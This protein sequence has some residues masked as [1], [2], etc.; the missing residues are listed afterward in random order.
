MGDLQSPLPPSFRFLCKPDESVAGGGCHADVY[1]PAG[2][3]EQLPV[4][5]MIH[6]GAFSA[7]NSAGIPYNQVRYLNSKHF[8]V[9]SLDYRFLPQ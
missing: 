5:I 3:A 8:V 2:A 1:L 9:V 7:G 6:G 4:A